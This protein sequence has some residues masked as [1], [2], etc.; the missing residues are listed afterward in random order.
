[1]T[2]CE[3]EWI[4]VYAYCDEST[5]ERSRSC[6]Q[7]GLVEH[8]PFRLQEMVWPSKLEPPR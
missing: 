6:K 5:V 1:M 4:V 8:Q 3:H 7:C 2:T